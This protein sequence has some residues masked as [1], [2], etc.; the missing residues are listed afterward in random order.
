MP[1]TPFVGPG[2]RGNPRLEYLPMRLSLVP[3]LFDHLWPPAAVLIHTSPPRNGRVSLGIEVNIIPAALERARRTGG[4]IVAQVN[5]HMPYTT[6]DAEIDVED[7][8]LAIEVDAPL[9]S[10]VPNPPDA[11]AAAIG[12]QVARFAV[13]LAAPS[14]SGSAR[15][16]TRPPIS[17]GPGAASGSGPRW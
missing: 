14:S 5:R 15:S 17:C 1:E 6:G 2:V 9:P 11:A 10:P 12:E 13:E 4:L 8:D 16:P 3:R 7:I